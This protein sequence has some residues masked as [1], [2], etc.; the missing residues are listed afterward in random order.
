MEPFMKRILALCAS[1]LLTAAACAQDRVAYDSGE[2]FAASAAQ[3][4]QPAEQLDQ[5]V[6]PVALYPDALLAQVL[7]ASTYPDEIA[8]AAGWMRKNSSLKGSQLADAVDAQAW[9]PSV[10]ALT[11]FPSVLANMGE[12]RSWTSALGEA[13]MNQPGS[14]M[15]EIQVLR[16]RAQAAG[17][18][19]STS[20][21]SV[22]AEDRTIVIQPANPA[23]VYVPA[24]DPWLVYGKPILA[25]PGWVGVPGIYYAGPGLYWGPGFDIGLFA[26]FGWGWHHW[27]FD[28]QHHALMHDHA[29]WRSH[30]AALGHFDHPGG[31]FEAP[32]PGLRGEAPRFEPH[33]E[34][35]GGFGHEGGFHGGGV[36]HG[37]GGHR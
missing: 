22:T 20:Q 34:E 17:A 23:V 30:I 36:S 10:K 5:L 18:L 19:R 26:G 24:Y 8:D 2:Y 7:A 28:W 37:G 35:H 13:Y 11:Q 12:N 21:Q 29:P 25:Y 9:D 3:A 6:A 33:F 32:S 31:R 16:Q 27:G 1:L 14:V 4:A 15:Q